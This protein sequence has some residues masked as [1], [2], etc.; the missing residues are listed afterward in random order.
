MFDP[1]DTPGGHVVVCILLLAVGAL[2]V[3]I[4]VPKG[5]DMIVF[6]LG[7][8]ARSMMGKS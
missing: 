1:I 8:L 7:V 4:G 2:F 3:K 5:E 6:S